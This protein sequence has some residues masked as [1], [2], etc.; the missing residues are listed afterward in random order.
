M[1]EKK[2]P[3]TSKKTRNLKPNIKRTILNPEKLPYD[4]DSNTL[5]INDQTF[6]GIKFNDQEL[7]MINFDKPTE[8]DDDDFIGM[9]VEFK[10]PELLIKYIF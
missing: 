6:T 5:T 7:L 10:Q 3:A 9:Y 1:S 4:F 2:L 8:Y